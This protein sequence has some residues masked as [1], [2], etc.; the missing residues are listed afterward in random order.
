[1]KNNK[2]VIVGGGSSGWMTAATLVKHFPEREIV[3]IEDP[4]TPT[5]GVGESTLGHFNDFLV[6]LDLEDKDWMKHCNATYKL[7]IKFTNWKDENHPSFHYPFGKIDSDFPGI[8]PS[9]WFLMKLD[10]PDWDVN[11]FAK[12][13]TSVIEMCDSAKFHDNK[14]ESIRNFDFRYDSAYHLDAALFGEYLK[15]DFC[16]PRGVTYI[17]DR[18]ESANLNDAGFVESINLKDG[19]IFEGDLFVDCTGFRAS[20]IETIYDSEFTSIN[21]ILLN[22]RAVVANIPYINQKEELE[23]ATNC[24]AIQSGWCWNIP[25]WNRIGAGYVYSSEFSSE[26][27]AEKD[28]R[29]YIASE[30]MING[31]SE[32]GQIRAEEAELKHIKIRH[33]YHKKPWINNVVAV[34]L[35]SGF[36]EPLESTGLLLT[37]ESIKHLTDALYNETTTRFVR[38]AFNVGISNVY[39]NFTS[40]LAIHYAFSQRQDTPYWN[41]V[42]QNID[43]FKEFETLGISSNGQMG[44]WAS[45]LFAVNELPEADGSTFLAAGLDINPMTKHSIARRS[46]NL[47]QTTANNGSLLERL[48]Q[49]DT[50]NRPEGALPSAREGAI[51]IL[52]HACMLN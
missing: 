49:I 37:H 10:N 16:I 18:Y 35:A 36:I 24:T 40:F 7:S 9:D 33:G 14:D 39:E 41:H 2:I 23:P 32:E 27:E 28:F 29:K 20:L 43:Y 6:S 26:E 51:N 34:G 11:H 31:N 17:S 22:D 19:G 8:G 42:T 25:L 12:T 50:N 44:K 13:Y 21:N 5:V 15:N 30:Q 45:G 48:T 4:D 38:E 52:Q 46:V 3:V 47:S 1:M